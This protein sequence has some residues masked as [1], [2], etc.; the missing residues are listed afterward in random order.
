MAKYV[1]GQDIGR[2]IDDDTWPTAVP[3]DGDAGIEMPR[4]IDAIGEDNPS[5]GQPMLVQT[6]ANFGANFGRALG[7][8]AAGGGNLEGFSASNAPPVPP[9]EWANTTT[10]MMRNLPNKY[11][12]RMLLTEIN[13]AGFLGTFDFLYLPIDPET[14]ANR[15][16]SFLNF[17]DP[18]FAWWFK[19]TYEGQK[20]ARFNSNKVVSV[21]PATLQGFEANYA[22]YA[23]SRVNRGDPSARPLFLREPKQG[24][25]QNAGGRN[26]GGKGSKKRNGQTL[27]GGGGCGASVPGLE[28]MGAM[29]M[30]PWNTMDF[31]NYLNFQDMSAGAP[32]PGAFGGDPAA[33]AELASANFGITPSKAPAAGG[34]NGK[35][36]ATTEPSRVPQFCPHCGGKIQPQFQFCPHCGGSLDFG[37]EDDEEEEEEDAGAQN[38]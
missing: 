23:S 5:S 4:T 9:V 16:Y 6:G 21:V 14:N 34:D 13:Q 30:P 26:A 18:R 28:A 7:G 3:G 20:M 22:H 11:T 17:V 38:W 25:G 8:G 32:F 10:I 19:N 33:L 27:G 36:N 37:D 15:G 12:Q 1:H 35:T 29:G 24:Q 2:Q 31:S